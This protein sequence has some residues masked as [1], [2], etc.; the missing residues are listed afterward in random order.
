MIVVTIGVSGSGKSTIGTALA[1]AIG[2]E[3]LEGDTVHP[4]ANIDKMSRG[5]PLDDEDR[6]PW[7]AKIHARMADAAE[8]GVD[9]GNSRSNSSS[10]RPIDVDPHGD[11]RHRDQL[12]TVLG[13]GRNPRGFD[14]LGN[15]RHLDGF[16]HVTAG[17]IDGGRA[18]ECHF[19]IG[20]IRR[21]QCLDDAHHVATR[22]VMRLE[23]INRDL[24][25]R[26]QR[27]CFDA[28]G[29]GESPHRQRLNPALSTSLRAALEHPVA[30]K[31]LALRFGSRLALCQISSLCP[32]RRT[33]P[34]VQ[35]LT[36]LRRI[37]NMIT[38]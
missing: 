25:T 28:A 36:G 5:I 10:H 23:I 21:D 35:H 6:R 7:L 14:H 8:R 11:A 20:L 3:F 1:R 17:Q 24:Q 12:N 27:H 26:I 33:G 31:R 18:L 16:A 38:V 9:L 29:P 13:D 32:S 2:C 30:T 34:A 37:P 4:Q 19:Y 15:H 22:E